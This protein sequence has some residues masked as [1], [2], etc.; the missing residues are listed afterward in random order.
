M[1]ALSLFIM[2]QIK[3][4]FRW[5]IIDSRLNKNLLENW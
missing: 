4:M 2:N 3:I 1:L 5:R